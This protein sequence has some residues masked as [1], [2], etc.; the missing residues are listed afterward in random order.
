VSAAA[1]DRLAAAPDTPRGNRTPAT[2]VKGPRADRYTMGAREP[3]STRPGGVYFARHG[4]TP[5]NAEGRFQGLGPVP[6]SARGR[7]QGTALA[8][9]ATTRGFVEL[10]CSPL[11]RA[12]ETADIVAARIGLVPIEDPRL[13]ETDTGDWTDRTFAS[14]RAEDPDGFAAFE[15]A[16]PDFAYPGGESLRH[17]TAR[18][19][20]ALEEIYR[21]PTPLLVVFHAMAIRLVFAAS[22][23]PIATVP[24][25]AL[26]DWSGAASSSGRAP[27]F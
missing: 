14:V 7:D 17:Q 23:A 27:D 8:E 22:G 6:L 4:E 25:A 2:G 20:E 21:R 13:V 9:A 15:R 19:L 3:E 11:V 5:Y 18:L 10:W 12:R 24:N 26:I 16:D 1:D